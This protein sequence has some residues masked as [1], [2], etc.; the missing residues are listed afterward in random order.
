MIFR[1]DVVYPPEHSPVKRTLNW[2][3]IKKNLRE[4]LK[5]RENFGTELQQ[6]Q[7]T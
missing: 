6:N 4:K 3:H 1:D 5:V 7:R 2:G